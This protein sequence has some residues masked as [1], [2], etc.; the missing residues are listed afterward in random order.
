ML[1]GL[2]PC[3]RTACCCVFLKDFQPVTVEFAKEQ[4][5]PLNIAKLTGL[6]GKLVCCLAYEH[7]F[8]REIKKN[9]PQVETMIKTEEGEAKV[10][11]VN[12]LT[13]L[14]T[15][16]FSDGRTKKMLVEELKKR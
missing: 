5:L 13:G 1:G 8:Y 10:K 3:G 4:N 9:F 12:Y 6:C 11:E 15:V 7:P 2:G 14:I 16:E